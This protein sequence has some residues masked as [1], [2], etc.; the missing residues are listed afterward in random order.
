VATAW[1]EVAV[2]ATEVKPE[3][4]PVGLI[5]L[6]ALA[7][8]GVMPVAAQAEEAPERAIVSVKY[9]YYQDS[10]SVRTRYPNYDGSEG[11]SFKRISVNSPSV[12]V[13]LPIDRQWSVEASGVYDEVSGASPKYY[14]DVSG[15][16][17]MSD[18]R[19][20]GDVKVTRY[21]ERAALGV[22]LAYST[23]RDYKSTALS[24][25][26]RM[27]SDDNNTTWNIGL[28]A[29][30]D[31][32]NPV[33]GGQHNVVDE[34]KGTAEVMVGVTQVAS[35][36]DLVQITL[37]QSVGRGYFSDPYK[38]YDHRPRRRNASVGL[39]RWNHH[40]EEGGATLR[41]SYRYYRDTFGVRAHTAEL[42]WVQPVSQTLKLTPSLRYATQS[43]AY[44]YNDPVTDTSLYPGPLGNPT[45]STTDQRM[46][47]FGAV[48]VGVK[49]E[50]Q[51]GVWTTD[52]K[53]EKYEQRSSW[54]IGGEGSPGIDPFHAVFVQFG[55]SRPF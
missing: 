19:T 51:L 49:A 21:F 6:A 22:G 3:R 48:T 16:S 26:G 39:L 10:Q 9:L 13:L 47:A 14:S 38:L 30:V 25:D 33:R 15:A 5:T 52:L 36:N 31:A 18:E 17:K 23:E 27:S 20:A 54:R 12:Q 37:S 4:R 45:F 35:R 44:F 41:S 8:P 42:G 53:L 29:T 43:S 24:I 28:G 2:A 34:H 50:L 55:V 32:I 40:F 1:A 7:L 11:S 46:S